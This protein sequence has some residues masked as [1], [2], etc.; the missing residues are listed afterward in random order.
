M[1]M[2]PGPTAVPE[3]VRAAMSQPIHNPDVQSEFATF[4][5][6]LTEELGEVFGTD[7]DIVILGGEGI[8]G[9]E[10]SLASIL[11]GGEDVLCLANGLFGEWFEEFVELHGG[12]PISCSTTG[13]E[14]LDVETAKSLL[15]S[16]D[17]EVA[18]MVHC[19][20]PTGTLNDLST[21]LSLCAEEGVTTIVDAVSSLGG[22]PVPTEDID[23]C[24]G[25][26]QKCLSSP[27]GLT[28][29]SV[30]DNAWDAIGETEQT[31]FYTSLA[32]WNDF[33]EQFPYTHLVSNLYALDES[34]ALVREEGLEHVY[35]RHDN[36][37]ELCREL[38]RELGLSTYAPTERCSPT[39]TAFEIED[40][41]AR[42][43]QRKL[44]NEHDIILATSLGDL[45]DNILRVGH[46]GTN[47]DQDNVERTMSALDDVLSQ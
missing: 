37:G 39:V 45:E 40:G 36:A 27:P 43:V 35:E 19:E 15:A 20:T 2:T 17:I 33:G 6:S 30:S 46:M 13:T 32:P 9:L 26:S 34:V 28:M 25:A 18:T 23:I 14:P 11:D 16:H 12:V 44:Q 8:L 22:T 7:D 21:I 42:T 31:S 3:R 24:I 4:Y 1:L 29:L 38:G 10:A 47:A 41:N 5:R